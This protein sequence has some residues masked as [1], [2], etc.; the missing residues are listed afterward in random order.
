M[1]RLP[2][3]VRFLLGC[4]MA[5]GVVAMT[6]EIV[7]LRAFPLLLAFPTVILAA[8]F[9]GLWGA[10]GCALTVAI[11]VDEFLT[12]AQFR[13]STGNFSQELRLVIFV[14]F[15]LLMGWSV[16]RLAQQKAELANQEL[17]RRLELAES[18]RILAEERVIAG[19]QLRYRDDVLKVALKASGMGL[20][21]W[22]LEKDVVH[23]SDE[24]YRIVGCEP[25]AYGSDPDAWQ[26]FVHPE[27]IPAIKETFAR[28]R[29]DGSDYRMQFRVRAMDGSLQWLESQGKCQIDGQG[30]VVRILG[31]LANINHRKLADQALL[32]AEKLAVAGRL[33]AS[34][35]HEI[36]NPMEAVANMLFLISMTD[37][38]EEARTQ[39]SSA[40][41]ELMRIALMA[42]ST[43]KFHRETG[44]PKITLLSDVIDSVLNMFRGKLQSMEI[45][46][47]LNAE[48]ERPIN[49]MPSETQQ[50]FANLIANAIEAMQ[51]NGRLHI[52]LRPSRDWRDRSTSGMRV[53]ICDTGAGIDR[54]TLSHIFEPFFT[55]KTETGTGLGL[56]VVAQLLERHKGSVRVWSSKRP[57]ATG[58]AFS[59][60]LPF[61]E[62][63]G[64]QGSSKKGEGSAALEPTSETSETSP[65]V[66]FLH[67]QYARV[68]LSI[69][70]LCRSDC[71]DPAHFRVPR[72]LDR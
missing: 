13:F 59:V 37:S 64:D 36:N 8:W 16:R 35:A 38:L 18:Q 19:E 71:G 61:G 48:R 41:D 26:L 21:V 67:H 69:P 12:R 17:K 4:F 6:S 11:L 60:F 53:T 10:A 45:A 33:A 49:C 50:I 25:G 42:Q 65:S 72:F 44:E 40:L 34:V 52:R 1:G 47:A 55:T 3:L 46:V 39:A 27:D 31:V 68:P 28:I 62:A 14:L 22:D 54:V 66:S 32:R 56:W 15:T 43:L 7:P 2:W 30:K 9:I 29:T 57:G 23:R 58:T 63:A 20:W 70:R 24:V 5:I 51:H